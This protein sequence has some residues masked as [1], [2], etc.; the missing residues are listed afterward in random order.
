MIGFIFGIVIFVLGGI[1]FFL[2][3]GVLKFNLSNIVVIL[4]MVNF[5]GFGLGSSNFINVILS[6]V[7]FS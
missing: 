6:I 7:I 3:I 2:G 1:G 4:V 5:S